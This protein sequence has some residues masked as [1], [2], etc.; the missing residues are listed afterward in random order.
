MLDHF[1]YYQLR[2]LEGWD[3]T[4]PHEERLLEAKMRLCESIDRPPFDNPVDNLGN[5]LR[6]TAILAY[7]LQFDLASIAQADLD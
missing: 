6:C 2:V 7:E 5:I 4:R 1:N 3:K